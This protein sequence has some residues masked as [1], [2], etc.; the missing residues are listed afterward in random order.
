MILDR[1]NGP[2]DLKN[3]NDPDLI[4]LSVEIRDQLLKTVSTT[5]GHLASNLGVVELTLALHKV[6]NSPVDKLIWDVGHQGY[7]HKLLTGRLKDFHS[8]RQHKGMSGFLK[9]S[10]SDHDI[11]EAGHSSTSISAA[12]GCALARDFKGEDNQVIAVIGDGAMTGGMAFEALNHASHKDLNMTIVLNDNDMSISENVGGLSQYLSKVRVQPSYSKL[13]GGTRAFFGSIPLIGEGI[14]QAIHNVKETVKHAVIQ[15]SLFQ[16]LGYQYFGPV[17]GHNLKDLI[18]VFENV[19]HIKGPKIVHVI[20]QKGKGYLPAMDAPEK[21]H[22]VSA[23]N[24]NEGVQP[25]CSPSISYSKVF[26]DTLMNLAEGNDKVV[27]VTAAMP[28]GTGLTGF[29]KKFPKRTIDVGIAE[30]HGVTMAAGLAIEGMKPV[31]AVYST[32][33]QRAYDQILHDVCLQNL[34]VVFAIDRAGLVGNDGETHH[35]MFDLS[36][37][38]HLPN[39]TVLAPKNGAELADMLRYA[40]E[41]HEGPIAIRYP[42]GNASTCE[43]VVH[44]VTVPEQVSKGD[45]GLILAVGKMVDLAEQAVLDLQKEGKSYSVVNIRKVF[46]VQKQWIRMKA[47]QYQRIVTLEDN[48]VSGAFGDA[49]SAILLESDWQGSFKKLGLPNQFIE[50]GDVKALFEELELSPEGLSQVLKSL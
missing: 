36:Y 33:L 41:E 19:K 2:E 24:V 30:Q 50:H 27:A 45:H 28:T 13:K 17:D 8:L 46:P 14:N 31:V 48:T 11:F 16:E 15:G 26:G 49:V 34:S 40:V 29:Q 43:E 38:G 12:V 23:F 20:T 42:R 1:L 5:G 4:R 7:V 22:G 3:L 32:F 39:M 6:Y 21:Y 25:K 18:E 35:G 10:E 44:P 47:K 37:L 9:R